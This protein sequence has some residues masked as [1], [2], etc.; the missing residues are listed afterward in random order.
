MPRPT[1]DYHRIRGHGDPCSPDR[2]GSTPWFRPIGF[3]SLWVWNSHRRIRSNFYR[4]PSPRKLGFRVL[5]RPGVRHPIPDHKIP[6]VFAVNSRDDKWNNSD[7]LALSTGAVE[8]PSERYS[9]CGIGCSRTSP[10]ARVRY[11]HRYYPGR[12]APGRRFAPVTGYYKAFA[13]RSMI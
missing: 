4:V 7:R 3:E 6:L 9:C 11:L 1:G 12:N 13:T 10:L 8:P 5:R 2:R